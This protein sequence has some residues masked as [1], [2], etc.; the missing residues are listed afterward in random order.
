MRVA[1]PPTR[2]RRACPRGRSGR[3]WTNGNSLSGTISI[4]RGALCAA[5]GISRPPGQRGSSLNLPLLTGG[6]RHAIILLSRGMGRHQTSRYLAV[7][8]GADA[9]EQPWFAWVRL[10]AGQTLAQ[11]LVRQLNDK[12]VE[13]LKK[14]AKEHGRSL[15]SEVKTI[16]G[17][18]GRCIKFS[19][20]PTTKALGN[21]I[22]RHAIILL[23]NGPSSNELE[24]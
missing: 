1:S 23:S 22:G 3:S 11:V 16:L 10:W 24:G 20:P 18:R 15:Q 19:K 2:Q 4:R 13:R 17:K 6:S 21:R 14:R 5:Y 9:D 7:S 8:G 12:L